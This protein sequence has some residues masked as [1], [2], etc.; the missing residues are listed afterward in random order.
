MVNKGSHIQQ[1]HRGKP[2]RSR[3][4]KM[5]GEGEYHRSGVIEGIF[6]G[7]ESK[8]HQLHC[9]FTRPDNRRQFGKIRTIA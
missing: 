6:C 2:Y 5:S 7:E 9:R 3:A 4:A 8:C 1:W